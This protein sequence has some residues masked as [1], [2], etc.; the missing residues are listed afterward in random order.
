MSASNLP[1]ARLSGAGH[2]SATAASSFSSRPGRFRS[3]CEYATLLAAR[4]SWFLAVGVALAD[5]TVPT[6]DEKLALV[7]TCEFAGCLHRFRLRRVTRTG[8]RGRL[9]LDFPQAAVRDDVN[10]TSS[11]AAKVPA[12]GNAQTSGAGTA[13]PLA[14]TKGR[15]RG[16]GEAMPPSG[17]APPG[18]KARSTHPEGTEPAPSANHE[19]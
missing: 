6:V 12:L 19:L 9:D 7:P 4:L 17:I 8:A 2:H 14:S 18:E 10:I 16:D 5:A 3:Q 11:H 1:P 13:C 15:A